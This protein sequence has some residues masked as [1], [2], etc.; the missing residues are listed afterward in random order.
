M[1]KAF[2]GIILSFQCKY[3]E[4]PFNKTCTISPSCADTLERDFYKSLNLILT[5]TSK[6]LLNMVML[7]IR[8][9]SIKSIKQAVAGLCQIFRKWYVLA[10]L[11]VLKIALK[12]TNVFFTQQFL[13]IFRQHAASI[14]GFVR[15]VSQLVCQKKCVRPFIGLHCGCVP[16]P[17][18]NKCVS[19][20]GYIVG[21]SP[22]LCVR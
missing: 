15:F 20:L 22:P 9:K 19:S 14:Y 2:L 12:R 3:F 16:P 18:E 10:L 4:F 17:C 8:R 7:G 5:K 13:P 1:F 21:V 6:T 11:K